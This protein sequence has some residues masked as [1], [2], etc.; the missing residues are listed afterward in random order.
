MVWADARLRDFEGECCAILACM[1]L[2]FQF[3]DQC[4]GQMELILSQLQKWNLGGKNGE[5][6]SKSFQ[7]V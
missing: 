3:G 5:F 1:K 6:P 2:E 4:C 7:T